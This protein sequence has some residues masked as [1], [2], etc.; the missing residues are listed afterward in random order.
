ME[1]DK[2]YLFILLLMFTAF[3]GTGKSRLASQAYLVQTGKIR[4]IDI[5]LPVVNLPEDIS[6]LISFKKC[7][8]ISTHHATQNLLLDYKLNNPCSYRT[9]V[10]RNF[11]NCRCVIKSHSVKKCNRKGL[12]PHN[13][14]RLRFF[15]KTVKPFSGLNCI[16]HFSQKIPFY[17]QFGYRMMQPL[18]CVSHLSV[19]RT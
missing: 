6:H 2:K 16:Q 11:S 12:P 14:T 3:G 7:R 5:I 13:N 4:L 15:S 19:Q 18:D 1:L 10:S 9:E 17:L 8:R